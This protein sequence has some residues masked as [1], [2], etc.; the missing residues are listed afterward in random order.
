MRAV[1]YDLSQ[2]TSKSLS[3]IP[4][5]E[6]ESVVTMGCEDECPLVRAQRRC[7]W[8]IP[9]PKSMESAKFREVRDLIRDKVNA[10]I[11]ER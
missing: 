7:D 6:F 11:G 5:I 4:D 3:E 10:L 9:D 2:H 1:G 8:Q